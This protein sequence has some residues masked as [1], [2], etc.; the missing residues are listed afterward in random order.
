MYLCCNSPYERHV[1]VLVFP[2]AFDVLD[3]GDYVTPRQEINQSIQQHLLDFKLSQDLQRFVACLEQVDKQLKCKSLKKQVKQLYCG[4]L[5][6]R[7]IGILDYSS[8]RLVKSPMT[9]L[10]YVALS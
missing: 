9:I 1:S 6:T 7:I 4:D 3:D 10:L 8:I 5:L 2:T